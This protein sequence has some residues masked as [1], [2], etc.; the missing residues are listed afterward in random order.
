M[1]KFILFLVTAC[2]LFAAPQAYFSPQDNLADRLIELIQ[3]EEKS[4]HVAIFILSNR[5]IA[6]ELLAANNR[7]VRVELICDPGTYKEK[8]AV[9]DLKE[10]GVKVFLF[11]PEKGPTYKKHKPIM[12]NKFALFAK[13]QNGKP[14]LWTGSFNFSYQA[15]VRNKENALVIDDLATIELFQKEYQEIKTHYCTAVK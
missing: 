4:I 7:G 10:K 2:A 1:K 8:S 14:L 6:K 15:T 12:H 3:K 9:K 5:K 13:N 11:D